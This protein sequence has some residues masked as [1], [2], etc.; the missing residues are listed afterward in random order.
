[1]EGKKAADEDHGPQWQC[2]SSLY[3]SLSSSRFF[4]K[5]T[6]PKKISSS[7]WP[8]WTSLNRRLASMCAPLSPSLYLWQLSLKYGPLMSSRLGLVPSLVKMDK[9]V[10][11]THDL[12]FSGRP[13]LLGQQKL[14]CN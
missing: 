1:M 7:A 9:E 6:K 11:R 10:M 2:S 4:S 12:E 14:F 3:L 13:S 8:L 5:R